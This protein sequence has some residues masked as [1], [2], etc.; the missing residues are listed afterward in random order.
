LSGNWS[1]HLDPPT[2]PS[3]FLPSENKLA[4]L[5]VARRVEADELFETLRTD[6]TLEQIAA[7]TAGLEARFAELYQGEG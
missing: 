2:A 3:A 7:E 4:V 1:A 5:Q 6:P